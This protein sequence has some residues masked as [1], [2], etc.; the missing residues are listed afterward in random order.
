M[1]V[2]V[3]VC[4]CRGCIISVRI[5]L[6][7]DAYELYFKSLKCYVSVRTYVI[8]IRLAYYCLLKAKQKD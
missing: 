2:C 4:V 5:V 8:V 3:C 7:Q 1:C 6:I